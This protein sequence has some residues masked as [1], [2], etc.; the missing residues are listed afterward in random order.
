[1]VAQKEYVSRLSSSRHSILS[2]YTSP[3][4]IT[5]N[6]MADLRVPSDTRQPATAPPD[7]PLLPFSGKTCDQ[8]NSLRVCMAQWHLYCEQC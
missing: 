8:Q 7:S 4:R 1:M 3:S 6:C 2:M 5:R